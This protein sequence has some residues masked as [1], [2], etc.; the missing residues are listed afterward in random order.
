MTQAE[1]K[2]PEIT[3]IQDAIITAEFGIQELTTANIALM[4]KQILE[5]PEKPETKEQYDNAYRYNVDAK[6]LLPRIEERRKELKAPVLE[7]GK[8]IDDTAK[9][10]VGMI[11]PLIDLSGSR[12]EAWEAKKAAE[13]AEK[14]QQEKI[15]LQN[16]QAKIDMLNHLSAKP[17]EYNR[18]AED[19]ARDIAH[20][21]AF[22]ISAIDFQERIGEAESI[23]STAIEIAKAALENR[24]KFE[25]DHAELARAKAEQE[26]ENKRLKE[27]R[28]KLE[29]ERKAHEESARIAREAL[30]AEKAEAAHATIVSEREA[31]WDIANIDNFNFD[32]AA[33]IVDHE[34]FKTSLQAEIDQARADAVTR[35]EQTEAARKAKEERFKLIG[36][37]KLILQA[38]AD[39]LDGVII[40]FDIPVLNTDEANALARDLI[41]DI[42]TNIHEFEQLGKDLK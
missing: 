24:K 3:N 41:A 29:A 37:D 32:H 34:E 7:K 21:E 23:K 17:M 16:I 20:L 28:A 42:K 35:W 31:F 30:E 5:I 26:A 27:E 25:A 12:R 14:E 11:Q 4:E 40:G 1:E 15:R 13:K 36:P 8:A 6:K 38:I 33:A 2:T 19:I 39:S 10:A 18:P 22:E 9:R